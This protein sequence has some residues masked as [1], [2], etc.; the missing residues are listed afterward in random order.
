MLAWGADAFGHL[1]RGIGDCVTAG[2]STSTDVPA[3]ATAV[4]VALHG[5]VT[6]RSALPG[7]PVAEQAPMLRH[8]VLALARVTGR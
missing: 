2:V 1:L 7:F 6:L 8:A 3:D 5:M 4:W